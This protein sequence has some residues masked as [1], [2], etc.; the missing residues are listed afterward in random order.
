[1]KL[2]RMSYR[3]VALALTFSVALSMSP[4]NAS[5]LSVNGD[6][7]VPVQVQVQAYESGQVYGF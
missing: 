2:I 6:D 4:L 1:M 5:A 3:I 7:A